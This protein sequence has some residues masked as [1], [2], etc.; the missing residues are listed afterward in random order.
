MLWHYA[1]GKPK[2]QVDLEVN[3]YEELAAIIGR[4]RQRWQDDQ[5]RQAALN[6]EVSGEPR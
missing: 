5:A 6:G 3:R 1:H 2:E 4:A